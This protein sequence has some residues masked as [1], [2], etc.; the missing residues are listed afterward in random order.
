MKK[1]LVILS[2]STLAACG[3]SES[4]KEVVVDSV[5]AVDTVPSVDTLL[6]SQDTTSNVVGGLLQDGTEVK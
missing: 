2:L 5:V 3:G 6:V 1:I 4:P